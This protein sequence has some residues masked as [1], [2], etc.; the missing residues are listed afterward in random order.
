MFYF[1]NEKSSKSLK[2]I[3]V[4]PRDCWRQRGGWKALLTFFVTQLNNTLTAMF[5]GHICI[6]VLWFYGYI[7]LSCLNVLILR[8]KIYASSKCGGLTLFYMVFLSCWVKNGSTGFLIKIINII[9]DFR[10]VTPDTIFSQIKRSADSFCIIWRGKKV[11][12]KSRPDS[13]MY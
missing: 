8:K 1:R 10:K 13:L 12:Q 9:L 2:S 7:S 11:T 3:W 6:Y 4:S 5:Y